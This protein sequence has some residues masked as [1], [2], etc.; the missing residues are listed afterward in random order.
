MPDYTSPEAMK[1]TNGRNN[2]MAHPGRYSGA[3]GD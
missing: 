2:A 1:R 3:A